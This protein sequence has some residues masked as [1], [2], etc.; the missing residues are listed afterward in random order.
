MAC[1]VR[2]LARAIRAWAEEHHQLSSGKLQTI[3]SWADTLDGIAIELIEAVANGRPNGS[4]LKALSLT[5]GGGLTVTASLVGIAVDGGQVTDR[6]T[7]PDQLLERIETGL[8]ET[9]ELLKPLEQQDSAYAFERGP[10]SVGSLAVAFTI[11][12]TSRSS[13]TSG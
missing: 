1:E 11:R 8:V 10:N 13:S 6:W 5:I 9:N 3:G 7:M 4:L 2:G 12:T